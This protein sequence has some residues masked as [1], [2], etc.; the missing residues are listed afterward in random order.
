MY[1]DKKELKLSIWQRDGYKCFY[2]DCD[3][4]ADNRS[5]DHLL[6]TCRGGVWSEKNLVASCKGCNRWKAHL[7]LSEHRLVE[8]FRRGLRKLCFP[9]EV[10]RKAA[11]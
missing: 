2:C 6:P 7:T 8:M 10:R 4:N 3:L 11:V 5:V 1:L 9:G